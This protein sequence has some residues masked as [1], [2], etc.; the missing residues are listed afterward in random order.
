MRVFGG[1][2]YREWGQSVNKP[3]KGMY[4]LGLSTIERAAGPGQV[5]GGG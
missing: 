1:G 3:C 2:A 4:F 5:N